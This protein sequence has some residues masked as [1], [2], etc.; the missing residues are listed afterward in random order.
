ML[1]CK[2]L[3]TEIP[4]TFVKRLFSLMVDY[5]VSCYIS[6]ITPTD[7]SPLSGKSCL[8]LARDT[9]VFFVNIL[10][11]FMLNVILLYLPYFMIE[12]K[13]YHFAL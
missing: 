12:S 4:D 6:M 10:I 13:I 9:N 1:Y 7:H 2:N 5:H 8:N 3:C 11:N